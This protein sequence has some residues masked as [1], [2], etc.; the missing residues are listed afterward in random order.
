MSMINVLPIE[1]EDL[2]ADGSA[3]RVLAATDGEHALP[4]VSPY[5]QGGPTGAL[6][7]LE[8]AEKLRTDEKLRRALGSGRP[9]SV[10]LA[11]PDGSGARLV[12]RSRRRITAGPRFQEQER[13]LRNA[14]A[15]L[16]LAAVWELRVEGWELFE[17][18]IQAYDEP[19]AEPFF[20]RLDRLVRQVGPLPL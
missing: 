12:V 20:S 6:L 2:L 17:G 16:R 15:G 5:L 13:R 1:I 10:L 18:T 19:V 9:I 3:V 7:H 4:V 14:Q 8:V 11:R